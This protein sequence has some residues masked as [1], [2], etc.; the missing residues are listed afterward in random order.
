MSVAVETT[1][2]S[3]AGTGVVGPYTYPFKIWVDSDLMV[4]KTDALGVETVLALNT[5]YTVSGAGITTGGTVM[6][7]A[8]LPAGSTLTL[9]RVHPYLQSQ[10]YTSLEAITA[11]SLNNAL[12]KLDHQIQQLKERTDRAFSLPRSSLVSGPLYLAPGASKLIGW[13]ASATALQN[14]PTATLSIPVIDHIGNHSDSL[15]TAITDIGVGKQLLMINKGITLS[16]GGTV[17]ENLELWIPRGGLV[18]LN[19]QTLNIAGPVS[20]GSYQ[21]FSGGGTVT[22]PKGLVGRIINPLWWYDGADLSAA[23]S[24]AVESGGVKSLVAANNVTIPITAGVSVDVKNWSTY[25]F[26][27]LEITSATELTMLDLNNGAL[28]DATARAYKVHVKLPQLTCTAATLTTSVGLK[29]YSVSR[30]YIEEGHIT[31]FYYGADLLPHDFMHLRG[32]KFLHNVIQCHVDSTWFTATKPIGTV[33]EDVIF[34]NKAGLTEQGLLWEGPFNQIMFRASSFSGDLSI[35]DC[36]FKN[37]AADETDY[38]N[39]QFDGTH[40]EQ[41]ANGI[42]RIWFEDVS[43][44][45]KAQEY[46]RLTFNNV[47]MSVPRYGV[48]MQFENSNLIR[49][50]NCGI[51]S[52]APLTLTNASTTA[53]SAVITTPTANTFT[54]TYTVDEVGLDP[55]TD[56][57]STVAPPLTSRVNFKLVWLTGTNAGEWSY[58]AVHVALSKSFKLLTAMPA[59]ISAG[60]TFKIMMVDVGMYLWGSGIIPGTKVLTVDSDTQITMDA[61][62]E[63]TR[64]AKTIIVNRATP[65]YLDSYCTDIVIDGKYSDGD[66]K[67]IYECPR[68]QITFLPER[69]IINGTPLVG[70]SAH[71]VVAADAGVYLDMQDEMGARYPT[72]GHPRGYVLRVSAKDT[73]SALSTTARVTIAKDAAHALVSGKRAELSLAG[74]PDSVVVEQDMTVEADP[75]GRIYLNAVEDTAMTL[76]ISVIEVIM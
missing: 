58:I 60:D 9:M 43:G 69:R 75:S 13:D 7:T 10:N 22:F 26:T 21:V 63:S 64:A 45:V 67:T 29:W 38:Y 23:M 2:V 5:D 74:V 48:G 39:V 15:E 47:H 55:T 62:C 54:E 59:N 52:A 76:T 66:A 44:G 1:K 33:F 30:A 24:A 40:F 36:H 41:G 50:K 37:T 16:A 25:D 57:T 46:R 32:T 56:F 49:L 68:S 14:Y 61:D 72:D 51:S 11:T 53:A 17:P 12:D 28:P 4:I 34:T 20:A 27:A 19:G 3:Y 73:N 70:Y 6:L 31:G 35:S 18:N 42:K 65:V 8:V 71:A